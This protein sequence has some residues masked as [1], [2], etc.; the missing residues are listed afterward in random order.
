MPGETVHDRKA[1]ELPIN[2][3]VSIAIVDDPYSDKGEKIEV[4]RSIRDDPLEGMKARRQVDDAQYLAGREWQKFNEQACVGSIRAID[5]TK[6]AVDGGQMPEPITDKQIKAFHQLYE[7]DRE[8]G[9]AG[10]TLVRD[11]LGFDRLSIAAA[12]AK[13]GFSGEREI[14]YIGRRFRECL[15]TLAKLWGFAGKR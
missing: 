10:K 15:E 6:E 11:I 8:L 3:V 4:L 2:A 9:A 5:P 14:N 13:H 7:A 12:A 1:S